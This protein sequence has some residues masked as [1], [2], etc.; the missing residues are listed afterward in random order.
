M[1]RQYWE[2]YKMSEFSKDHY[3]INIGRQYGSGGR[4][5]AFK[6]GERLGIK[7]Y[8]TE[9]ITETAKRTGFSPEFFK[10]TDEKVRKFSLFSAF[11]H[12]IQYEST[13]FMDGNELFLIQ[14]N[15]IRAIAKSE[16]AI[17]VGRCA[18]YILR[19]HPRIAN[20]FICAPDEARIERV[21]KRRDVSADEARARIEQVDK[22]RAE[23]YNY[24]TF[25]EWGVA[26]TYHLCVDSSV[27]GIDGTIDF[28]LEFIDKK[29]KIL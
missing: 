13:N 1:T 20:V 28:I 27:L 22:K 29:I 5:V 18:D 4:E 6:L 12:G 21:M 23:Y 8:D 19:D 26:H 2:E 14:S 10:K 7:A 16:S 17:F 11:S 24:Y 3:V 25:G 9:I 15:T